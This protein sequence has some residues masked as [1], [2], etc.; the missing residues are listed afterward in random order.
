MA[1]RLADQS[2]PIIWKSQSYKSNPPALGRGGVHQAKEVS[3][4]KTSG[5]SHWAPVTYGR[6][7][8][9]ADPKSLIVSHLR[10]SFLKKISICQAFNLKKF[11]KIP[12]P[13]AGNLAI[14]C[15]ALLS[16]HCTLENDTRSFIWCRDSNNNRA[17]WFRASCFASLALP[18]ARRAGRFV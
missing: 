3:F 13:L 7:D 10:T 6:G 1:T 11:K 14:L 15:D 12:P 18:C 16:P 8:P 4:L 9:R 5:L 17:S 2:R